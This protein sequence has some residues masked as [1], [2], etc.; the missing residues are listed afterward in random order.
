MGLIS[1]RP[2]SPMTRVLMIHLVFEAIVF[3]LAI[4]GMIMVSG[5][6]PTVAFVAGGAAALLALVA[7]GLLRTP[8]GWPLGWLVQAVGIAL[9][10]ATDMMYWVGAIFA[11]LWVLIFVLGRAVDQ[12]AGSGA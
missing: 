12:R 7:A 5:V 10:A 6:S 4:P 3:G 1:L 11:A 8:V 2:G 9:G